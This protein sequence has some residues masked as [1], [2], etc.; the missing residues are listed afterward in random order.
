MR[1][2]RSLG[3]FVIIAVTMLSVPAS[4]LGAG[5]RTPRLPTSA[6]DWATF[7]S[8]EQ[9]SALVYEKSLYDSAA[10]AGTLS[11][12]SASATDG[13]AGAMSAESI[14]SVA[15]QCGLSWTFVGSGTWTYGWAYV[16]TSFAAYQIYAG[17]P[18]ASTDDQFI[19]A[20]T[21]LQYFYAYSV[22]AGSSY[23]YAQSD[24]NFKWFFENINYRIKSWMGAQQY[25][26]GAW[27]LGPNAYCTYSANP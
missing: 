7:S 9:A 17:H 10:A 21:V 15:A 24:S 13:T 11:W 19:R 20:G 23:E 26:N 16:D 3:M 1:I 4:A 2:A 5:P 12:T 25:Q 27:Q 6:A 18:P 8:Q 14:T 22:G